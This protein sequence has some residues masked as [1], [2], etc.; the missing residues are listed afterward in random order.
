MTVWILILIGIELI[1]YFL[2][3]SRLVTVTKDRKPQLFAVVGSPSAWD[4]LIIGFGPADSYISKLEA[5]RDQVADEP[6]IVMLMRAVR[7]LYI[8]LV[9]TFCVGFVVMIAYAN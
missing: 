7:G 6:Q 2:L 5:H 8:A 9:V 4:Y 3:L 1:G